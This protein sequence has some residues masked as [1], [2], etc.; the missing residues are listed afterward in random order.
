MLGRGPIHG[1]PYVD[2]LRKIATVTVSFAATGQTTLYTIPAGKLFI[3]H[4]LFIRAGADAGNTEVTFG[5]VGTLTD[6]LDTRTLSNLDAV[7]DVVKVEI[8]NATTPTKSKTYAAGVVLQIDVT[9]ALGGA[10]NYVDLFGYLI[11]V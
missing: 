6:W 4:K 11:D 2:C 10:T 9:T 8:L 7:G 3:P 5:R 1:V